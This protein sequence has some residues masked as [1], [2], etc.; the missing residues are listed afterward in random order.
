VAT[1]PA[2][3]YSSLAA[4]ADKV[5]DYPKPPSGTPSNA[6]PEEYRRLVAGNLLPGFRRESQE[7][8]T[9]E[10]R[11]R[12]IF[13]I[14]DTEYA[15]GMPAPV[16]RG[17]VNFEYDRSILGGE[18][19]AMGIKRFSATLEGGPNASPADLL[20]VAIRLSQ[21][22][23]FFSKQTVNGVTYEPDVIRRI[24]VREIDMLNSNIIQF[25]VEAIGNSIMSASFGGGAT[26]PQGTPFRSGGLLVNILST[27]A[28]APSGGTAIAFEFAPTTYPD[29]FGNFGVYRVTPSWY[30]PELT[31]LQKT[32]NTT[33]VLQAS[34]KESVVYEFPVAF[35]N[36]VINTAADSQRVHL[37]KDNSKSRKDSSVLASGPA[38][39]YLSVRSM[40]R[41]AVE[42][43]MCVMPSQDLTAADVPFQI[44]KP[45]TVVMQELEAVRMNA[46]PERSLLPMPA[47]AVVLSEDFPVHGGV[48]DAN[49]NRMMAAIFSRVFTIA[50]PGG[51]DA[52][53]YFNKASGSNTYRQ[54]WPGRSTVLA[55]VGTMKLPYLPTRDLDAFGNPNTVGDEKF[56]TTL[57]E[58]AGYVA[59]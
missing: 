15:R 32:W 28:L 57:G 5:P 59:T 3:G 18:S 35:F 41:H 47:N 19:S 27:L 22:R 11:T 17:D 50:D 30:D 9:D 2:Y 37:G 38:N 58:P 24:V 55:N 29:A 16:R 46:A 49:N 45:R 39:P 13:T 6:F 12:M 8:A 40:E 10:T 25:E 36:A 1:A 52:N 44:R 21:N 4:S 14:V 7:W 53:T 56:E 23:I 34:E 51:A 33:V 54:S 31:E 43:H 42:T 20:V 26:V 48:A